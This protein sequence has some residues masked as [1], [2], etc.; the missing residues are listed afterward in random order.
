MATQAFSHNTHTQTKHACIWVESKHLNHHLIAYKQPNKL[1][2]QTYISKHHQASHSKLGNSGRSK[3][4]L[5]LDIAAGILIQTNLSDLLLDWELLE[6][7]FLAKGWELLKQRREK[8]KLDEKWNN[9]RLSLFSTHLHGRAGKSA[10]ECTKGKWRKLIS[11]ASQDWNLPKGIIRRPH[12]SGKLPTHP[13][14][15][16]NSQSIP[17]FYF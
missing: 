9:S 13:W 1:E 10:R 7:G 6:T 14:I 2:I 8:L 17:E 3:K 16:I 4:H 11:R 12:Y 15:L 5:P